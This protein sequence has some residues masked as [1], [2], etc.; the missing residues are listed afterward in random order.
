MI[1]NNNVIFEKDYKISLNR[2]AK[3]SE[4][5]SDTDRRD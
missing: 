4:R 1:V 2:A 5:L 3:D